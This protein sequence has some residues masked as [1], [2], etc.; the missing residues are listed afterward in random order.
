MPS[1]LLEPGALESGQLDWAF[2]GKSQRT[3]ILQPDTPTDGSKVNARGVWHHWVD[4]RVPNQDA[5]LVKDEGDLYA[6]SGHVEIEKGEMINPAIGAL[7]RYEEAW[8]ELRNM[9][10]APWIVLQTVTLE[11]SSHEESRS[12]NVRGIILRVGDFCQGILRTEINVVVQRWMLDKVL[13]KWQ[14]LFNVGPE[15]SA[16]HK[17]CYKILFGCD[18]DNLD[19]GAEFEED[20]FKWR[21]LESSSST[22]QAN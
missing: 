3:L 14:L 22:P 4:S 5:A 19:A 6:G 9:E 21:V 1:P 12:Q 17:M 10:K 18:E 2:A 20:K 16:C 15:N 7:Q 11:N 13:K 8:E